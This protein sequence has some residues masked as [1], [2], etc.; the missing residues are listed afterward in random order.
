MATAS[1]D[2]NVLLRLCLNDVPD[3]HQRARRLIGSVT[4][5]F[6][7]HPV[8]IMEL[9]HALDHHYRLARADIAALL[10]QVL[11]L[12]A[13]TGDH[14]VALAAAGLFETHPAL[15]FADCYLAEEAA[16]TGRVPLWT[17]DEKLARQHSAAQVVDR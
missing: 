5:Q 4:A 1:L 9:V 16:S 3:H 17:F 8:V 15:S 12:P 7:V 10:R 2:A 11:A 14:S 6:A 13:I